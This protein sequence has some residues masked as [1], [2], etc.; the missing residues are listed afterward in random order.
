MAED[1][2][3]DIDIEEEKHIGQQ[4]RVVEAPSP[5]RCSQTFISTTNTGNFFIML[6]E[7]EV[8]DYRGQRS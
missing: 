5:E 3:E 6:K 7:G 2:E 1:P 4:K 8:E